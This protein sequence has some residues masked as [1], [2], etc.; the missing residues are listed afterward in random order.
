MRNASP[1]RQRLAAPVLVL[2]AALVAGCTVPF[3]EAELRETV[4]LAGRALGNGR[5]GPQ[6]DLPAKPSLADYVKY[7]LA[8]NPGLVSSYHNWLATVERVPQ[9]RAMPDPRL[10]FGYFLSE[11]ETRVGPQRAR[12]GI[13]QP[14]P[15]PGKRSARAEVAVKSAQVAHAAYEASARAVV[16][17]VE[18][19]WWEYWYLARATGVTEENAALLKQLEGV[20]RTKYTVGTTR[21]SA[22]IKAQVELGKL[23]NRLAELRD[24]RAP[25]SAKL[26]TAIGRAP[27]KVL[28]WPTDEPPSRAD[29]HLDYDDLLAKAEGQNPSLKQAE[30]QASR[31]TAAR[32]LARVEQRVDFGV[33]LDYVFTDESTAA[34][35]ES[36]K[37]PFAIGFSIGL[38][39][40]RERRRAAVREAEAT[41]SAARLT[42]EDRRNE[43]ALALKLAVFGYRD[44]ARR[45]SLYDGTL[46]PQA[47]QAFEVT[48]TAFEADRATSLDLIDAQRTL[49]EF[50]LARERAR[51]DLQIRRAE[52]RLLAG[53]TVCSGKKG[54]TP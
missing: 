45:V 19:A 51:A 38:P 52:M 20:L 26:A 47:R 44:A 11:V 9:A 34:M 2:C 10:S 36:G 42:H 49:L 43:L 32:E 1:H 14:L 7:A 31:A 33:S 30:L 25:L 54:R 21:N 18:S 29:A 28:P 12:V 22:L 53:P 24:L 6:A 23:E 8:N 27:A 40:A 5:D 15:A 46:L 48:R 35:S 4:E 41:E 13:A 50:S 16:N 39:I 17:R 3:E 37:D